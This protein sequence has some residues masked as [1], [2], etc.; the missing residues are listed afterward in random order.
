MIT[1][2]ALNTTNTVAFENMNCSMQV[3][4]YDKTVVRFHYLLLVASVSGNFLIRSDKCVANFPYYVSLM[5]APEAK[6]SSIARVWASSSQT[7][8]VEKLFHHKLQA[9]SSNLKCANYANKFWPLSTILQQW[10]STS[11]TNLNS[12]VFLDNQSNVPSTSKITVV[13]QPWTM[14]SSFPQTLQTIC[15]EI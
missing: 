15:M 1:N 5:W 6:S 2:L 11:G 12:S 9:V 4:G 7:R 14:Q 3:P 13:M 10:D 8:P